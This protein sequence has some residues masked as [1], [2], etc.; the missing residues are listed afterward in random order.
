MKFHKKVP[1]PKAKLQKNYS[2][3]LG[4]QHFY[5]TI[6]S[7][8]QLWLLTTVFSILKAKRYV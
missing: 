4:V 3:E 5:S 8:R 6:V 1:L 2:T 7:R